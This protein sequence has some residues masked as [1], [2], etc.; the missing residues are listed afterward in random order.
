MPKILLNFGCI[1][2]KTDF[3][4]LFY[5]GKKNY[6]PKIVIPMCLIFILKRGEKTFLP[7]KSRIYYI[8]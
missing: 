1:N 3:G 8:S 7:N 6:M 2:F 4:S 5:D